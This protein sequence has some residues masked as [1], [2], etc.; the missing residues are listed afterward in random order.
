M[1]SYNLYCGK[2]SITVGGT[3]TGSEFA[4]KEKIEYYDTF[5]KDCLDGKFPGCDFF[6]AGDGDELLSMLKKQFTYIESAGGYVLNN[7]G[8][9]LVIFRNG[10]W[11]LPKGKVEAGISRPEIVRKLTQT[12]HFYRWKDSPQIFMKCTYWFLM[13][14]KGSGKTNPQTEEGIT[15]AM[16]ADDG[17]IDEMIARTHRNLHV[18]FQ[19]KKDGRI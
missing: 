12:Y 16:W 6:I 5:I 15:T 18:L 14:Y 19:F 11:D 4:K 1:S 17:M 7:V 10:L 13:E 2:T 8:Q 9:S 3:G